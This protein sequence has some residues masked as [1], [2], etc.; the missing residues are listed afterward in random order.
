MSGANQLLRTLDAQE[1]FETS[2]LVKDINEQRQNPQQTP[3]KEILPFLDFIERF[4]TNQKE[5]LNMYSLD[6]YLLSRG[7]KTNS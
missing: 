4:R 1:I 6:L 2:P 3:K 5:K 7:P